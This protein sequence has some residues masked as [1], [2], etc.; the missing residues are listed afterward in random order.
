ML[1]IDKNALN[2]LNQIKPTLP[3]ILRKSDVNT[4]SKTALKCFEKDVFANDVYNLITG[5]KS[6]EY[7]TKIIEK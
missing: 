1:A 4:L 6:N 7:H 5:E 3:L 2:K